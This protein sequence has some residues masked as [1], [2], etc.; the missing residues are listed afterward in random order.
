MTEQQ[1]LSREIYVGKLA[2]VRI[3]LFSHSS[4]HYIS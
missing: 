2:W 1:K 4:T 3:T